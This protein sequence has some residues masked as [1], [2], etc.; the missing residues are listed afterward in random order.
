[1]K[2]VF[3]TIFVL[4][5]FSIF[6][7]KEDEKDHTVG[8]HQIFYAGFQV[9]THGMGVGIRRGSHRTARIKRLYE[10]QF[11]TLKHP[12]EVRLLPSDG[13]DGFTFAK[14]NSCYTFRVGTGE[15][16]IVAFKPFGVGVELKAIYFFGFSTA[17]L[18]PIHYLMVYGDDLEATMETFD[19]KRHDVYNIYGVGPYFKGFSELSVQPGIFGKFALN[20]EYAVERTSIRSL[21]VGAVVDGYVKNVKI[22][23]FANNYPVYVSLYLSLQFGKKWYR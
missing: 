17:L 5:S 15:H 12:R 13:S 4:V 10:A 21:E 2:N 19:E 20:F 23:A 7:Q 14:V 1:M 8:Y 18:K 16:R 3:I 6:S 11:T 9:N 22:L